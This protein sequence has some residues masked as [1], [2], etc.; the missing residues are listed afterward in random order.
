MDFKA[1]CDNYNIANK[2]TSGFNPQSNRIIEQVHM[3]LADILLMFKLEERELNSED[4]FTE[5]LNAG[6]FAIWA[7]YHTT[8]G[9]SPGQLVF[10]RDMILP[11]AFNANWDRIKHQQQE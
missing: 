8:L 7:T 11:I 3:V 6:A 2:P 9:C 5:F 10:G 4:P 1:M